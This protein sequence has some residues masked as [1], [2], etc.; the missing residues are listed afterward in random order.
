[1]LYLTERVKHN[2]HDFEELQGVNKQ[3]LQVLRSVAAHNAMMVKGISEFCS[4]LSLSGLTRTLNSLE[5]KGAIVRKLNRE[6]RRSFIV[7]ITKSGQRI[8]DRYHEFMEH[9]AELML[10]SLTTAERLMLIELYA[11]VWSALAEEDA[12]EELHILV[13]AA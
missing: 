9:S 3:E 4:E 7:E 10:Q 13:N 11:K 6:D 2:T 8:V 12:E 5:E 1:M